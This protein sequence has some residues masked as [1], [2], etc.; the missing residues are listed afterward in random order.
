MVIFSSFY[1][2]T[3]GTNFELNPA[4]GTPIE[5]AERASR[6]VRIVKDSFPNSDGPEVW[7]KDGNVAKI[8]GWSA[9]NF[10]NSTF[11]VSYEFDNDTNKENGYSQYAYE[12]DINSGIVK[13]I[14]GDSYLE[15][16]YRELGFI[17]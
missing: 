13:P 1:S 2:D 8:Y 15:K 3:G 6:A 12:V 4:E 16:K 11:F 10:N 17:D 5:K 14:G 9:F 7:V